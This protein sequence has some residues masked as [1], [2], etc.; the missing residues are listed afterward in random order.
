MDVK[1]TCYFNGF[2]Y[3]SLDMTLLIVD[4]KGAGFVAENPTMEQVVVDYMLPVA[5]RARP[6]SYNPT[7]LV[8]ARNQK[9]NWHCNLPYGKTGRRIEP[10]RVRKSRCMGN[11]SLRM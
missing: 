1:F 9:Q 3:H 11:A 6:G 4:F 5:N 2:K 8:G 7:S 10:Q